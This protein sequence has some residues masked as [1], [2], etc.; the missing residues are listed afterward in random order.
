MLIEMNLL[1]FS[2]YI[3]NLKLDDE[4]TKYVL[5]KIFLFKY[6]SPNIITL[7]GLLAD[8]FIL[9]FL[10]NK[11]LFFLALFLFLRYSADCLDGAVARKYKKV[12]DLG[13]I[14]DTLADNTLIFVV[15]YGIFFLLGLD[16]LIIPFLVVSLNL[17]YLFKK[18]AIIHHA[19]VKKKVKGDF[20]HNFYGYF[21]NNN[22]LLYIG[23]FLI[24]FILIN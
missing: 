8:F 7:I 9:Y 21:V 14:L 5:D 17:L 24:F 2:K 22:I 1:S 20:F 10:I 19:S 11:S 6:I 4:Y 16:N 18:K 13:G 3:V 23:I 12:S 15:I